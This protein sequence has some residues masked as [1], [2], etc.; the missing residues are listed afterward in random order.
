MK[1]KMIFVT[2]CALGILGMVMLVLAGLNESVWWEAPRDYGNITLIASGL[3]L[4]ALI[5]NAWLTI[6]KKRR[7]KKGLEQRAAEGKPSRKVRV[8]FLITFI[9]FCLVVVSFIIAGVVFGNPR[10][11][12]LLGTA[13]AFG[14]IVHVVYALSERKEKREQDEKED[15][16]E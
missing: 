16:E 10:L 9:I 4:V 8:L 14:V 7:V 11:S 15:A 3:M 1:D 2:E 13:L 6:R 5:T 12:L